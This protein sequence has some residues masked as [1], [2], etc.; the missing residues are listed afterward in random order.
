MMAALDFLANPGSVHVR[1]WVD[2]GAHTGRINIYCIGEDSTLEQDFDN[3]RIVAPLPKWISRLPKFVRY[4]LLGLWIRIWGPQSA[5]FH[6]HNSSGYGLA[7]AV[8]GR[9]YILTTYGS[10]IFQARKNGWLYKAIVRF[11]LSRA[12]AITAT[13]RQMATVVEQNFGVSPDKIVTFSLGVP[14]PFFETVSQAPRAT[15]IGPVWFYNRRILPLYNTLEAVRAFKAFKSG[16]G[17]GRLIL[18]KGDAS[19]PYF[20]SVENEAKGRAD[21]TLI[22]EYLTQSKM[23]ALL[24]QCDFTI[25]IP[26]TDQLSSAILEGLARGKPPILRAINSYAPIAECSILTDP[27]KPDTEAMLEAFQKTASFSK[28]KMA[29]LERG[30]K[31]LAQSQYSKQCAVDTYRQIIKQHLLTNE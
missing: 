5:K 14:D 13:A 17:R 15:N 16:G 20:E 29:A 21:I 30:C 24:D 7:A 26:E 2:L 9:P 25:S 11:A 31:A 10:E 6:A 22:S 19:G 1:Q 28:A 23:I 12:A 4:V 27:E 8:T 3:I 18:L